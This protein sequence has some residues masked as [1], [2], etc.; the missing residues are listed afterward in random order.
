MFNIGKK[1]HKKRGFRWRR[2]QKSNR[3]EFIAM[4]I[5]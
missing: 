5:Y 3:N 2:T 4:Y 1:N